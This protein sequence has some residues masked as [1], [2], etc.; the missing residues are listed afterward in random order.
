MTFHFIMCQSQQQLAQQSAQDA[1][2]QSALVV[3]QAV[4]A[5]SEVQRETVAA[6]HDTT[7]EVL[8]S[9]AKVAKLTAE[10]AK[11]FAQV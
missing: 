7:Q 2:K 8:K 10:A 1:Q 9:Q 4:Q 11:H 6:L 5:V 3:R